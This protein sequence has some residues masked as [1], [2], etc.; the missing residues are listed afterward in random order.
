AIA[1]AFRYKVRFRTSRGDNPGFAPTPCAPGSDR[2]PYC[3]DAAEAE[4]VRDRVDCLLQ[5]WR[6]D[7][8]A[9]S[10]S[11]Q[12]RLDAYLTRNFSVGP[13]GD[14]GFER[15]YTELL[16][17][18]GDE[19]LTQAF[20]ARYDLAGQTRGAFPGSGLEP[21]GIDLSGVAGAELRGLYAA[22]QHYDEAL[23]RFYALAPTLWCATQRAQG[24][25]VTPET[26]TAWFERVLRA[27][28]QKAR[29]Q[30]ATA[31]RYFQFDQG[32]LARGVVRRAFAG[33]FLESVVM[34]RMVLAVVEDVPAQAR[35]Q[36]RRFLEDA[37]ARVRAALL[38]MQSVA[39][40]LEDGVDAFGFAPDHVPFVSVDVRETNAFE[41]ALDQAES[42]L[43]LAAER[44]RRAL[45]DDHGFETV[46]GRFQAELVS[47]RNTYENQ[48]ADICGSFEAP[49][50]GV[51]PATRAHAP[52]LP[53]LELLGDP[54]GLVGNGAIHQTLGAIETSS[55]EL[56]GVVQQMQNVEAEIAI[57]RRAV[58]ERCGLF[59]EQVERA[60]RVGAERITLQDDIRTN[61]FRIE[62]ARA[63][64]K[65]AEVLVQAV[66][67]DP[68]DPILGWRC[69]IPLAAFAVYSGV[70]QEVEK[71]VYGR[72]QEILADQRRIDEIEVDT[73]VWELEQRCPAAEVQAGAR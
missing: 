13:D 9:L 17:M 46:A 60:R 67:C 29:A 49:D 1:R 6:D 26:V 3:Y 27:S 7:Y 69:A 64:L 58:A 40:R 43:P 63:G 61:Q 20:A 34:A 31:R 11:T 16:V 14:D 18:L 19:H 25:F 52:L 10:A 32:E 50:G 68:F 51:Y 59:A 62:R 21:G 42:R 4:A 39:R 37:Q 47:I 22:T 71:G 41:R 70:F 23:E 2:V 12:R 53:A 65:E 57:E 35:P 48:L 54:C 24:D 55:I 15:L 73:A 36:I 38:D 8:G 56:R 44:E 72:G 28:T 66:N 5:V 45:E 30:S 33:A